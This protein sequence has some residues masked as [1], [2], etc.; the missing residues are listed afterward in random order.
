[1]YE[2]D[3]DPKNLAE[4]ADNAEKKANE[5]PTKDKT[6]MWPC[7]QCG[8]SFKMGYNEEKKKDLPLNPDGSRHQKWKYPPKKENGKDVWEWTCT[9]S[10][11]DWAKKKEWSGGFTKKPEY[12]QDFPLT[13]EQLIE[14]LS[15]E[16]E[17]KV[18][19]IIFQESIKTTQHTL[20][21]FA[22][23][24]AVCEKLGNTKSAFVGMIFKI[25]EKT[26]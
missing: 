22:G 13:S 3:K 1:M 12:N 9:K 15:K 16:M 14:I 18:F 10:S 5:N 23:C 20:A 6:L 24:L 19:E 7:E 26:E 21:K 4:F 2:E 11:S 17:P 25:G 8:G